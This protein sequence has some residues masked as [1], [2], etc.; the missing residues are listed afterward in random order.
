M[1]IVL[2][3]VKPI[4]TIAK[5]ITVIDEEIAQLISDCEYDE[6]LQQESWENIEELR[7]ARAYRDMLRNLR[8]DLIRARNAR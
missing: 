1:C 5:Q 8:M 3:S 4:N 2:S 6:M 7:L